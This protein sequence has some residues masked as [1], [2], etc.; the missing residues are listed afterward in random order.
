MKITEASPDHF[1]RTVPENDEMSNYITASGGE[2]SQ[3]TCVSLWLVTTG[4][5][6]RVSSTPFWA[7]V[8]TSA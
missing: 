1:R 4:T 2:V 8:F 5:G 6:K 3:G 7:V